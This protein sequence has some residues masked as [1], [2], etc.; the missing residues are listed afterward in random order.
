MLKLKN[1]VLFEINISEVALLNLSFATFVYQEESHLAVNEIRMHPVCVTTKED[2]FPS[3]GRR[4]LTLWLWC[5]HRVAHL[6]WW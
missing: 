4:N 5:F 3:R 1:D 2:F 6:P